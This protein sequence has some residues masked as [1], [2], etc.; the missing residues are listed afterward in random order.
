MRTIAIALAALALSAS[1]G[2]ARNDMPK[3]E[4]AQLPQDKVQAIKDTCK[5]KWA[6]DFDMRLYCE[7]KQYR[8][9]QA[10]IERNK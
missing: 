7:D 4:I 9:L 1:A 5:G 8:A 2:F 3:S 10:L 6:D